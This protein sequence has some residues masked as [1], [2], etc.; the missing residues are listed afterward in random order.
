MSIVHTSLN[1]QL[2]IPLAAEVHSRPSLRLVGPETLTHLAVYSRIDASVDTDL[3]PWQHELL[4]SL[5]QF[6]GVSGPN[7]G[8]KYFFHDFGNFRLQ[9]EAHTEFATYT[10]AE[11][12]AGNL[13]LDAWGEQ[14]PLRHVPQKWLESLN[15]RVMAATHVLLRPLSMPRHRSS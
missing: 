8:A 13:Q 7:G 12:H 14:V 4:T 11:H 3:G 9:W 5:C 1:H 6:F 15:G 10:F 2:R